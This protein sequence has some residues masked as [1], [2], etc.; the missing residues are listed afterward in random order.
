MCS[1]D[2]YYL[3][4]L[5]TDIVVGGVKGPIANAA[6]WINQNVID[7]VLRYTGKGAVGA[8]GFVYGY[9]DQRGI[10][11]VYNGTAA[12]TGGLGGLTR[13]LQTGRLQDY[14]L[15]VLF[16]LGAIALALAIIN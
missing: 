13:K 15:F 14:A 11:G 5:Y 10:D 2:L 8:A 1:S 12:A 4:V 6:Y 7:N 3:D 9:I 16:G